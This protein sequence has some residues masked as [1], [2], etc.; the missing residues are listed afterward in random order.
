MKIIVE[1]LIKLLETVIYIFVI[2]SLLIMTM[3]L[4]GYNN[5]GVVHVLHVFLIDVFVIAFYLL[6]KFI[7]S[8][9]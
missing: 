6:L 7:Y 2:L 8:R 4:F 5:T 3:F 9:I 1:F